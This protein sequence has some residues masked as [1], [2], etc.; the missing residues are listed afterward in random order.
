MDE[1]VIKRIMPHSEE[2]EQ[3]VIGSM[4]MSRPAIQTASETLTEDDY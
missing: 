4:L 2:A 1:A 3:A